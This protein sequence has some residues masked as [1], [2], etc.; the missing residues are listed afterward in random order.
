MQPALRPYQ[1]E[2]I[3]WLTT[4]RSDNPNRLLVH[5]PGLGKTA[6][7]IKAVTIIDAKNV[8][9]AC[10]AVARPVWENELLRWWPPGQARP[11]VLVIQPGMPVLQTQVPRPGWTII[12]YSALSL[13]ANP[14]TATLAALDWDVLI[15][16][17][18][19][20]LKGRSNRTHAVYGSRLDRAKGSLT[21]LAE[22][23]W[24][25]SGTPAPNHAGELYPHIR[26][27][28][29]R[30]LPPNIRNDVEF[31]NRYCNV[32]ETIYGRRIAGSNLQ[33]LADLRQRLR[34]HVLR[35]R[36]EDVA[37]DLPPLSFYDT[38]VE[39]TED[40]ALDLSSNAVL[41]N[42]APAV[43]RIAESQGDDRLIEVLQ[44]HEI[45]LATMRRLTGTLKVPAAVA[46]IE[47]LLEELPVN[48]RKVVVFGYHR[49]V[50]N[51][52]AAGLSEWN[53]V[54]LEGAT[55]PGKRTDVIRAFQEDPK[56]GVFV[57][58]IQAAGT[59]ITLTAAH[60]AVFVECSWVPSENLQA[61][62]RIHRLGQRDACTVH[63]L[64]VPKSLDQRIMRAFRRKAGEL[65]QLLDHQQGEVN[66]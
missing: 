40:L 9:V 15:L 44:Q 30:I 4:D 50:I 8:L 5:D 33:A 43:V 36:R 52:V 10:P 37:Q 3:R 45:N 56:V 65:T 29:P 21:A 54:I 17:E 19:Q 55:S 53:A 1:R 13:T 22:R 35:R 47:E 32:R 34:P 41:R 31:E 27:L 25:L 46:F 12:A 38:P 39:L 28:F 26:T 61:A 66:A 18:C 16:D 14:W 58:Q 20:Y 64:Y 59:A 48:Q 62:L 63:F 23:V 57:G 11:R 2:S 6:T 42:T 60:V 49:D 51:T 7:A 24:L